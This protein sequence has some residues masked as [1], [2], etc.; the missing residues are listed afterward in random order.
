MNR[1]TYQLKQAGALTI[2]AASLCLAGQ[3]KLAKD[4]PLDSD[5]PVNV[6]VQFTQ[7]PTAK[8]HAKVAAEGGRLQADLSVSHAGLY[9]IPAK[10]LRGLANDPDV[11]FISP[12]RPLHS[13]LNYV[14]PAVNANMAFQSGWDGT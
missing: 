7:P 5:F 4:L 13:T 9:S 6:I 11:K 12:D 8:S 10:A 2:L 14:T 3:E 1:V